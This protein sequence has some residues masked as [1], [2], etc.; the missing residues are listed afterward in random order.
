M[1]HNDR[2]KA[3]AIH[4][5]PKERFVELTRSNMGLECYEGVN[6]TDILQTQIRALST[7][8]SDAEEFGLVIQSIDEFLN[9]PR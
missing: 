8:S 9:W 4:V 2:S 3:I 5:P 1:A 6:S 7:V